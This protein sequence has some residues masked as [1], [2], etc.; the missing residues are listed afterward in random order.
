M[1]IAERFEALEGPYEGRRFDKIKNKRSSRR[2]IHAYLLLDELFPKP[3]SDMV[4]AVE[5][6]VIYL[7]IEPV[8]ID[9]LNDEQIIELARCGVF[10]EEETES[11]AMFR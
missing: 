2:D 8:D 1:T 5:H 9:K 11:L 6:D 3:G 7:D 4:S 10:Y